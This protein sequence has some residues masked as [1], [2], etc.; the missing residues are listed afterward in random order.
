MSS[1]P[2][3]GALP[4]VP[5]ALQPSIIAMSEQGHAQQGKGCVLIDAAN[6]KA[7]YYPLDKL[8]S[9]TNVIPATLAS[10]LAHSFQ[11]DDS[12]THRFIVVH[13]N[14]V[15]VFAKTVNDAASA[16]PPEGAARS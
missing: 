9:A 12:T 14:R 15:H 7:T 5:P 3:A 2:K 10:E 13:E 6:N 1:S 4:Y 16:L 11:N 8:P